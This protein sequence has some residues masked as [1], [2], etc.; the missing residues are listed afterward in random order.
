MEISED[1]P[2]INYPDTGFTPFKFRKVDESGNPLANATFQLFSCTEHH[3]HDLL[4]NLDESG[5][6]WKPMDTNPAVTS[7]EDGIVEFQE[8]S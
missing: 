3:T 5:S 7:G 6:C 8:T 4:A 1:K 2:I